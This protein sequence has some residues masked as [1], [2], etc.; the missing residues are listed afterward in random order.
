ML[1]QYS[2]SDNTTDLRPQYMVEMPKMRKINTVNAVRI[3][4]AR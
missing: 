2:T 1:V 4:F 3:M